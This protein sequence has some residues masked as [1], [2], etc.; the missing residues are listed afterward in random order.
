LNK[1]LHGSWGD[2]Y[3]ILF[4]VEFFFLHFF[5]WTLFISDMDW[6]TCESVLV[7]M[8]FLVCCLFW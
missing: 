6:D 5:Y 2:G 1:S 3:C 8:C 7:T 4:R